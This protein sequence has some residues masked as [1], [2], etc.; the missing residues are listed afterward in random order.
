MYET[1]D[2]LELHLKI[3]PY[4]DVEE[5][6]SIIQK[7]HISGNVISKTDDIDSDNQQPKLNEI[8]NRKILE[9]KFNSIGFDT[10]N[11][12]DRY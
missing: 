9:K 8:M 6:I 2:N 4:T 10:I 5:L 11:I 7:L 3:N 12:Y 1:I